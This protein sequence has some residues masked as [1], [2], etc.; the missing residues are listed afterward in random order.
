MILIKWLTTCEQVCVGRERTECDDS[1][2]LNASSNKQ[3]VSYCPEY[4]KGRKGKKQKTWIQHLTTPGRRNS[5]Q[6]SS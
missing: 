3:K 2:H 4:S 5:L 6:G 1:K